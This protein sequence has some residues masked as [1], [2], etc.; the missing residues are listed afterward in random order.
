[1]RVW[2]DVFSGDEMVSDSY[3]Q[4]MIFQD[5]CLEVQA[6]F[7]T[8]GN[9]QIDIGCR[10]GDDDD[11]GEGETVINIVD[12]HQLQETQLSKKDF[13]G[14]VK[15]YLKRV[16]AHLK[17]KGKE[18]RVAEFQKGATEM[19]KFIISKFDEMQIFTGTSYDT[20]AGLAF[21]YTKDGETEPVFM[22]FTDGMREEKF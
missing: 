6:K 8:K 20:E 10:D 4:Q 1:M 22:F 15:G 9:E 19:I 12:A 7:V 13:M 14:I 16:V 17:E 18:E 5:A 3:K 2:I 21:S 11:G